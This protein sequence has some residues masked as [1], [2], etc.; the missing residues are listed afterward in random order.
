[1]RACVLALFCTAL[2]CDATDETA[3]RGFM[4]ADTSS[5]FSL[6]LSPLTTI[7]FRPGDPAGSRWNVYTH[8]V[9]AY[10]ALTR[11]R[12]L[13]QV[14]LEF[15]AR[16]GDVHVPTGAWLMNDVIWT[17][18]HRDGVETRV[19]LDDG[20][21][22]QVTNQGNTLQVVGDSLAIVS[23]RVGPVAPFA[24]VSLLFSGVRTRLYNTSPSALP[25]FVVDAPNLRFIGFKDCPLG[26][27]GN[28]AALPAPVIDVNGGTFVAVGFSGHVDD[29]AF[30]GAGT[31][32]MRLLSPNFNGGLGSAENYNFPAFTGAIVTVNGQ[33]DRA[34]VNAIVTAATYNAQF[35]EL[36][37]VDSSAQAVVVTAPKARAPSGDR[38][39]VKA[40]AGTN[41]ISVV[42]ANGELIDNGAL[43]AAGQ[44]R[45]WVSDGAKWLCVGAN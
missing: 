7:V 5:A 36:V 2:A 28:D 27:V 19:T 40:V 6:P 10:A 1:M 31:V 8:W 33:R 32:Q 12:E 14:Y 41:P 23:D 22:I 44:A 9:D 26:G 29:N 42:D 13:G 45:T 30:K 15:D 37:R 43:S 35:N 38:F 18:T 17:D 21:Q 25:A 4:Q 3:P 34:R 16:F 11:V 24:G 20:A 39:M